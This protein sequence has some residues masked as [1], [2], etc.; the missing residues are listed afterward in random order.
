MPDQFFSDRAGGHR[1]RRRGGVAAAES[2]SRIGNGTRRRRRD[3]RRFRRLLLQEHRSLLLWRRHGPAHGGRRVPAFER[4]PAGEK[5]SGAQRRE[6]AGRRAASL[7]GRRKP[8]E[9]RRRRPTPSRTCSPSAQSQRAGCERRHAAPSCGEDAFRDGSAGV[10]RGWR[11]RAIENKNGSTPFDLATRTTGRGGSGS[12]LARQQQAEILAL[13]LEAG[14]RPGS[15]RP[16]K[17]RR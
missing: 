13:L 8:L 7:R 10:V 9:S 11:R 5:G 6:S 17:R 4:P 1:R 15:A 16:M 3:P 2:R 14:A 12:P